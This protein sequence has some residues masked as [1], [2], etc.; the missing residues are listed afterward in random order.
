[1]RNNEIGIPK[2]MANSIGKLWVCWGCR[3]TLEFLFKLYIIAKLP[4]PQPKS[5]LWEI[6]SMADFQILILIGVV[7]K[8]IEFNLVNI[9]PKSAKKNWLTKGNIFN[10]KNTQ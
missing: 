9:P 1:M 2:L 3:L 7:E 10:K 6:N 4:A 8:L 5:G